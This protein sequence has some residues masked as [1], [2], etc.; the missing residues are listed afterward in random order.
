MLFDLLCIKNLAYSIA[1][2]LRGGL[3][4]SN[5]SI[6]PCQLDIVEDSPVQI[7]GGRQD[8]VVVKAEHVEREVMGCFSREVGHS[9]LMASSE[10]QN[11]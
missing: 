11:G 8:E 5:V 4:G 2:H 7:F 9:E 3:Q 6:G 10:D 1:D